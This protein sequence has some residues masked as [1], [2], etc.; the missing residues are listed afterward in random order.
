MK[1]RLISERKNRNTKVQSSRSI[2]DKLL[3]RRNP[4]FPPSDRT[5]R[6]RIHLRQQI[7]GEWRVIN[8]K[9]PKGLICASQGTFDQ[10]GPAEIL[11]G[12]RIDLE[13]QRLQ[14]IHF[15]KHRAIEETPRAMTLGRKES[16]H[17]WRF[18]GQAGSKFCP[19]RKHSLAFS[20][21]PYSSH[22]SPRQR[23]CSA[24]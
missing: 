13:F 23:Y 12:P 18:F 20:I 1:H 4:N 2:L 9:T 15:F 10:Y 7:P 22:F 5:R 11:G 6:F 21:S 19:I 24:S 14:E 16:R 3:Q 17:A 8:E